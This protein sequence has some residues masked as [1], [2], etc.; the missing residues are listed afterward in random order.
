[1]DAFLQDL[2]LSAWYCRFVDYENAPASFDVVE[3]TSER[4]LVQKTI[5]LADL[6]DWTN[7]REVRE[8][9]S[10]PVPKFK[11]VHIIYDPQTWYKI[12]SRS[13]FD[14]IF[15]RFRIEPYAKCI[16]LA[17]QQEF[18]QPRKDHADDVWTFLLDAGR[19]TVIWSYST[20]TA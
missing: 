1:M 10:S 15:R 12:I 14:A 3:S 20:R 18:S 17:S 2:E 6:D 13:L 8:N 9:E 16:V 11:L 7:D 4:S 19:A 5:P